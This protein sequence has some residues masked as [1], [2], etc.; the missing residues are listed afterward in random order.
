MIVFD[1]ETTGLLK[2]E[3]AEIGM[4]PYITELYACKVDKDFNFIGE[5]DT[6]IKPPVP[7]SE[8]IT[9]CTGIDDSMV[10]DAPSFLQIYDDLYDFFLGETVMVAHNAM[11]DKGMLR[12]ELTRHDLELSFPWPKHTVCTVELSQPIRNRRLKLTDLHEIAT[13]RP[14]ENAH[15]AKTDV[16]GLMRCFEWLVKEGFYIPE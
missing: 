9:K 15:R 7:I 12:W 14:L 3:L 11:F 5:F 16:M 8:F 2:P 10:A 13:G 1:T 4:Q 6:F